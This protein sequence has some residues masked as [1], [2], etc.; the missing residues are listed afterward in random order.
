ML[1]LNFK[2]RLYWSHKFWSK[3]FDFYFTYISKTR[4]SQWSDSFPYNIRVFPSCVMERTRSVPGQQLLAFATGLAH[5]RVFRGAHLPQ[6]M[7]VSSRKREYLDGFDI[8]F[9][10]EVVFGHHIN[11]SLAQRK[12]CWHIDGFNF[13]CYVLLVLV[14]WK[15]SSS[16]VW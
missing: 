11:T 5:E 16:S 7:K 2:A 3:L 13:A 8:S 14:Q 10:F 1:F 15:K 12:S 4:I 9:R 6:T